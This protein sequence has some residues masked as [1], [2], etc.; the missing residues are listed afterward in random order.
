MANEN[1]FGFEIKPHKYENFL[2]K[3][4]SIAMDGGRMVGGKLVGILR[5]EDALILNPTQVGSYS[6]SGEFSVKIVEEDSS[7]RLSGVQSIFPSTE[8]DVRN[9]CEFVKIKEKLQNQITQPNG[10]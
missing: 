1:R 4:V 2:G 10:Q 7:H 5:D 6:S 9:Y 3:Y 8:E